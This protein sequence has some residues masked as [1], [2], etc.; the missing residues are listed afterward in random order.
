MEDNEYKILDFTFEQ[1]ENEKI[2][3]KSFNYEHKYIITK[4][5]YEFGIK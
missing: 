2:E 3:I 4:S 1:N 5:N